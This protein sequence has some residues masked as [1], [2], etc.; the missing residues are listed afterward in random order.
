MRAAGVLAWRRVQE[1][2]GR[3]LPRNSSNS[4]GSVLLLA[5]LGLAITYG[6]MGVINMAHG[7]LLMVGAYSTWAMQS[8]FRAYLP[9]C[10]DWYLVAAIPVGLSGRGAGRRGHG[11][12]R[13]PPSLWPPLETLLATWG[14]AVAD[15][16]C[17]HAVRRAE[18]RAANPCG[19]P[20]ASN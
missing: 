11:A 9:E 1:V 3:F 2:R 15:A 7:E 17:A 14:V 19:C 6:V 8:V 4:L 13:H 12:H 10:V 20:A 18:R 5:A 16:G